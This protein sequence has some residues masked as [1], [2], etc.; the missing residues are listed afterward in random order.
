M[1]INFKMFCTLLIFN[2]MKQ[3]FILLTLF[4]VA[5]FLGTDVL[6]QTIS[7]EEAM[8]KAVSLRGKT[9]AALP[10]AA[11][12]RSPKLAYTAQEQGNTYYYVFNYADKGFAIIGGDKVA[13]DVLGYSDEGTFNPDSIP[14]GL[15]VMLQAY[16]G[17]I[18]L[19]KR[20]GVARPVATGGA[21]ADVAP[22]ITTQWDQSEPFNSMLPSLGEF[23]TGNYALATGCAATAV[24]Q[25]M[26]YYNYP[27]HG[28][29]SNSYQAIWTINGKNKTLTFEADFE[30]TFY[31]WNNMLDVYS[32]GSYDETQAKAVGTLMYHA[33][34]AMNMEYGQIIGGGSGAYIGSE[35]QALIDHFGYRTDAVHKYREDYETDAA[36]EDEI[37]QELAAYHPIIYSGLAEDGSGH[38]FICDGY[39]ASKDM[40]HFNWGWGGYCDGYYPLTG[41]YALQPTGNG[42]GGASVDDAAYTDYQNAWI[43]LFPMGDPC[44]TPMLSF[45]DGKIKLTTSTPEAT[46]RCNISVGPIDENG[47][48]ST[49]TLT[50]FATATGRLQSAP[51]VVDLL[52][53]LKSANGDLNRDGSISTA[54]VTTLVNM[55]LGK[56]K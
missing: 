44:E 47:C 50:A 9:T 27:A 6:G 49:L 29:G 40:Y 5:L 10:G 36:W 41:A 15:R 51:L 37:Y 34:V 22:L 26:K 19:T 55:I 17:Q 12:A 30:N 33:G 42:I 3:R 46:C 16:Q 24:S 48:I 53:M 43:G 28:T 20:V 14:D 38:C 4:V 8:R 56:D 2:V 39:D 45:V 52:A 54:D 13:R 23:F 35:G 31:D 1:H 32:Y 7:V 18:A 11:A 21:K 25:L